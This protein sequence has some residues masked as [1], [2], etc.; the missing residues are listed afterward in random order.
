MTHRRAGDPDPGP[1]LDC[2]TAGTGY[3]RVAAAAR[4]DRPAPAAAV[5]PTGPPVVALVRSPGGVLQIR[6]VPQ[7]ATPEETLARARARLRIHERTREAA[8]TRLLATFK[9]TAAAAPAP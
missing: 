7:G 6:I 4:R 2:R 5:E 1:A 3:T 8:R 9:A